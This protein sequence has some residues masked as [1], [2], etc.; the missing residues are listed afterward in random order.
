MNRYRVLNVSVVLILSLI[1]ICVFLFE[2]NRNL[3][4]LNDHNSEYLNSIELRATVNTPYLPI[5]DMRNMYDSFS[6]L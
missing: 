1:F 4:F 2:F 6:L 3:V 5:D